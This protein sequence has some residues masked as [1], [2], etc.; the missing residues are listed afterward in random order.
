MGKLSERPARTS[1]SV[2]YLMGPPGAQR[3]RPHTARHS[4]GMAVFVMPCSGFFRIGVEALSDECLVAVISGRERA[5]VEE[6]VKLD[7]LLYTGSYGLDIAGPGGWRLQR[8]RGAQVL[9][10]IERAEKALREGL[11]SV[12][13]V[14]IERKK[15]SVAVHYRLVADAD[16]KAVQGAVNAAL[17]RYQD[18]RKMEGQK[19]Y[20]LQTRIGWDNGTAVLWLLQKRQFD[21]VCT[22]PIY[23]GDDITDEDA[24]H[25]VKDCGFSLVV[26]KTSRP[27]AA[28]YTLDSPNE[29]QEFLRRLIPIAWLASQR[30]SISSLA[31]YE[32]TP[33]ELETNMQLGSSKPTSRPIIKGAPGE[34]D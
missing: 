24:F 21:E 4:E 7:S 16:L 9:P 32:R 10:V 27:T 3:I 14:I 29:V 18:L 8:E 31:V 12:K 13:G 1:P 15:Y 23:L 25:A 34:L 19:V 20:E 26:E 6:E 30:S 17:S 5:D 22:L 33:G 11:S 2:Q 28:R